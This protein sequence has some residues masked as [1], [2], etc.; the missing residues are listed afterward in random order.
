MSDSGFYRQRSYLEG[1][2]EG[3]YFLRIEGSEEINLRSHN[4]AIM[5]QIEHS[6]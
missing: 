5:V 4:N 3:K 2:V 6:V 1:E